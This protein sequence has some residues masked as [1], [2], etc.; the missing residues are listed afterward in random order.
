MAIFYA[1][2]IGIDIT[3]PARAAMFAYGMLSFY[4]I[5]AAAILGL[6]WRSWWRDAQLTGPAHG[7]DIIV[8]TALVFVTAGYTSPFFIFFIFLLLAAAIRWGWK[9]TALT[10]LLL[11]MLYFA[12][13]F[14]AVTSEVDFEL[15]RF[16][17]RT[18]PTV[19]LD[20]FF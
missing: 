13:G 12:T 2:A 4:L 5:F 16:V 11:V 3:Q 19:S 1:I 7:V 14:L 9:E 15:Y 10:A 6:T 20:R 8:F 18:A 17:I